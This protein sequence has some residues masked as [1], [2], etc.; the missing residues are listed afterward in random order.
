[1]QC[2]CVI[3]SSVACLA[4][5]YFTTSSH[6]RAVFEKIVIEGIMCVLTFCT[7]FVFEKFLILRRIKRNIIREVYLSS[8]IVTAIPVKF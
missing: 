8:L 7:S 6:K 1:M 4:S 3:L 2:A 5:Q